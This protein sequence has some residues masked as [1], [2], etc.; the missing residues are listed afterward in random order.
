MA[1]DRPPILP[2]GRKRRRTGGDT[3]IDFTSF[4]DDTLTV[5][6]ANLAPHVRRGVSGMML[7]QYE[8][9]FTEATKR[10]MDVVKVS[11]PPGSR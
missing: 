2:R 6:L 7:Q 1:D 4:P 9:A 5:Y 11:R 8:A 3:P 10:G